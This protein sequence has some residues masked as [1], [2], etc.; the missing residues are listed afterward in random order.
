[1]R[2]DLEHVP[3]GL[4]LAEYCDEQIQRTHSNLGDRIRQILRFPA[5]R[6]RRDLF[7]SSTNLSSSSPS[8]SSPSCPAP[9]TALSRSHSSSYSGQPSSKHARCSSQ[10]SPRVSRKSS[11]PCQCDITP[12]KLEARP[13]LPL[14]RPGHTSRIN[15]AYRSSSDHPVAFKSLPV[16]HPDAAKHVP[17][18]RPNQAYSRSLSQSNKSKD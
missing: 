1:M 3:E 17:G 16:Q 7:L 8:T 14:P 10:P 6:S 2:G 13:S 15:T 18:L 4:K 12:G 9:S 11:M 5:P